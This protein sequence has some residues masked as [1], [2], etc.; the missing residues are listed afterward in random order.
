MDLLNGQIREMNRHDMSNRQILIESNRGHLFL[1]HRVSSMK[2]KHELFWRQGDFGY[3]KDVADSL[4]T[5]C[6]H[7]KPV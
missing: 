7:E 2:E 5:L 6:K 1:L 3:V 4:M